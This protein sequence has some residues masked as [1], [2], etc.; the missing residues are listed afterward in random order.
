[1]ERVLIIG[2]GSIGERH[3]RCFQATGLA[4]VSGCEPNAETRER[5]SK[6]Y[7]CPMY[8]STEQ[9]WKSGDF[10]AAVI[11]TP[12]QTHMPVAAECLERGLHLL[13]EKPLSISLDG[14]EGVVRLAQAKKR[15]VGV[16]YVHRF[17]LALIRTREIL[18]QGMIG[19]VRQVSV[20]S[21]QHFPTFR[22]AYR[23]IYYARHECGG[24]AIQDALTHLFHTISWLAS[25]FRSVFAY[26][27]HFVLEGVEV[28]DTVSVSGTLENGALASFSFNQ[29]QAPNE[30]VLSFHGPRGSIRT[31]LHLGRVGIFLPGDAAWRWETVPQEER[32]A[33]F[34]RQANSF[35]DAIHGKAATLATLN[36]GLAILHVNRAALESARTRQEIRL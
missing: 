4:E 34:I 20:E 32:D 7:R 5:I 14:V 23:T 26:A 17:I 30:T 31:E 11:C 24:G 12:A 33:M 6:T 13:I 8:G 21:G 29:F 15:A 18:E 1:M 25:P 22:P 10:D 19:E 3:L 27:G 35:L 36:D 16:A 9:A 2:T 28:E